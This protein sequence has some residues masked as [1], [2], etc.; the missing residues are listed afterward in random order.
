VT[1]AA[2]QPGGGL[3]VRLREELRDYAIVAGYLYVCLGVLA[4][5]KTAIL[6]D[7]GVPFSPLGFALF[8]ALVL[9]KFALLGKA[10]GLGRGHG[11]PLWARVAVKA[12]LFAALLVVLS[13]I[14]ELVAGWW[15]EGSRAAGIAHVLALVP[16]T[17]VADGLVLVL[18]AAPLLAV[19][20]V[21][22]ALGP[23]EFRRLV[24]R[25]P[26]GG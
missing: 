14:E 15:R 5:Y 11:R 12:V 1:T 9:G 26:A 20:E 4:L 18:V 13:V 6:R 2:H 3:P 21:A 25:P 17:V 16:L 23:V 7:A 22:R 19:V 24:G 8:K 10:A